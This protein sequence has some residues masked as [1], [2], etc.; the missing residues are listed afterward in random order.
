MVLFLAAACAAQD[1]R[2]WINRGVQAFRNAQYP[3][4]VASFQRAVDLDP[5]FLTARL[6]LGTA[7]MQQYI[8]GSEAPENVA[9]AQRAESEFRAVLAQDP[10]QKVALAS[11][12]SLEL[13]QKKWDAA[14]EL[15]KQLSTV[16]PNNAEAYYSLAF[17]DWAQWYPAYG[18]ARAAA[19]LKPQDPGPI[20]DPGVRS[21]LRSQ[22]WS[23]LDDGILNLNRALEINPQYDDAMAY[24]NLFIRE[25]A[26]LRD[27]KAEYQ[28]DV[29][30]AD[31][32][33]GKA[34]AA[35]A[36]RSGRRMAGTPGLA[37]P[38]PPPPPPP[39]NRASSNDQAGSSVPGRIRIEGSIQQ[40][41]IVSQTQPVYP[42]LALQ[43]RIEGQV[44]F[45][46]IIDKQGRVADL[47]VVSG[48]PLL[49]PAAL[50]AVKQWVYRPTLLNGDPVEV[51]T[52][53]NVNFA[54]GAPPL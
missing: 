46:A 25:R 24:L 7:F 44:H 1:A 17:I 41:N 34:L 54:L 4:A 8:P 27:T 30:V 48:H 28:Q 33:V 42:P 12:A 49:I 6:Y 9:N 2:E 52:E 40:R 3:E 47:R 37:P 39:P 20:A 11:L 36:A 32:W 50:D 35:K 51:I 14:R 38:P 15:Y 21:A 16:D 13:N 45:T 23:T 19:G 22:W 31:E 53:I 43:A 26:D 5:S 29:A 10:A 18:K